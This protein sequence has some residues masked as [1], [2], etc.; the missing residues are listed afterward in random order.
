MKNLF[1]QE[2]VQELKRRLDSLTLTSPRHWGK[3]N[4][5]QAV[6]HCA[7]AFDIASGD[8]GTPNAGL[9]LKIIGRLI[10]PLVFRDDAPIRRN[11]TTAKELV[12]ADDRDL[13]HER[14]RLRI[15]IDRFASAGPAGCTTH[16]HFVFGQ[17]TPMQ[18]AI[19]MYKHTDHHLRQFGA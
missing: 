19:L 12:V 17:L 6:A 15:A 8:R 18:W 10:K 5:A 11:V 13:A 2:R 14:E 1:E 9:G 16:P 3:M 4:A 7:I